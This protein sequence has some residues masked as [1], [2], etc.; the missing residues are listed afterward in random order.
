MSICIALGPENA[1]FVNASK[2]WAFDIREM[3]LGPNESFLVLY[4][5]SDGTDKLHYRNLPAGLQGWL[6]RNG[7]SVRHHASLQC[8]L[9]PYGAFFAVDINGTVRG[10][11]SA[12]MENACKERSLPN[13]VWR[14]GTMPTSATFGPDGQFFITTGGGGGY[15]NLAGTKG[16]L[17]KTLEALNSLKDI[18]ER[19]WY[20]QWRGW[21]AAVPD[22]NNFEADLQEHLRNQR[23]PV[24]TKSVSQFQPQHTHQRRSSNIVK[25]MNIGFKLMNNVMSGGGGGSVNDFVNYIPSIPI[26]TNGFNAGDPD[27][28]TPIQNAAGGPIQ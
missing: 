5:D 9:G 10:N 4:I 6:I 8:S 11:L 12:A 2:R 15:W 20:N 28:W 14:A 23:A 19:H 18:L 22:F 27:F 24:Q 16:E 21:S 26:P 25:G 17:N 1:Y 3:A 13:G 7:A